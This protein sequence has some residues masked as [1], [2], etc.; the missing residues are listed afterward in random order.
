MAAR[1]KCL[2]TCE[3]LENIGDFSVYSAARN[4]VSA[5]TAEAVPARRA[6]CGAGTGYLR[7]GEGAGRTPACYRGGFRADK[8]CGPDGGSVGVLCGMTQ[9]VCSGAVQHIIVD[10]AALFLTDVPVCLRETIRVCRRFDS[11]I[12]GSIWRRNAIRSLH[13]SPVVPHTGVEASAAAG[14]LSGYLICAVY[15]AFVP[16]ILFHNCSSCVIIA[17]CVEKLRDPLC[18]GFRPWRCSLTG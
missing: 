8:P 17:G 3:Q 12:P 6:A 10:R 18:T 1:D 7:A 16:Y 11:Q 9:R 13:L 2:P 15:D 5:A 14:G 4:G